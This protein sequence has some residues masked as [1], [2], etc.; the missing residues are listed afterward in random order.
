[1]NHEEW[2]ALSG[3]LESYPVEIPNN[4]SVL[5]RPRTLG[6]NPDKVIPLYF[7]AKFF[8]MLKTALQNYSRFIDN[9]D[10]AVERGID[11][12]GTVTKYIAEG[13]LTAKGIAVPKQFVDRLYLLVLFPSLAVR[14]PHG[15]LLTYF[16]DN[17]T[18]TVNEKL[19]T[20]V[21]TVAKKQKGTRF[22]R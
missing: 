2:T 1:M 7:D 3:K 10:H 18:R 14:N 19:A 22:R 12:N 4:R 17:D 8:A 13:Q 11:Q 20:T 21:Q 9:A 16:L 6:S 5:I 15:I